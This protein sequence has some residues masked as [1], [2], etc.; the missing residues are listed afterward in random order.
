MDLATVASFLLVGACWGCTTPLMK[1]GTNAPPKHPSEREPAS[2]KFALNPGSKHGAKM[3]II[4][5]LWGPLAS[6]SRAKVVIP[7]LINQSGS[8]LYYYL[9]GSQ[10][11]SMAVPVCNSLTFLFTAVTA[12]VMGE[13]FQQPTRTLM[14]MALVV[15]GISVC[16]HSKA[17]A[18]PEK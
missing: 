4:F 2:Q 1:E 12:W 10:D 9:L 6:L 14:G 15:L 11:V 18:S 5:R 16:I 8:I 17:H 13:K 3:G 7:Y